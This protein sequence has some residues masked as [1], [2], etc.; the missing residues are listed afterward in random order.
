MSM[1][2]ICMVW[3]RGMC[4]VDMGDVFLWEKNSSCGRR[5]YGCGRCLLVGEENMA[6][7]DVFFSEKN[8][9]TLDMI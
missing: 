4:C 3:R 1:D 6:R 2:P 8:I 9:Y 5:L 7:E